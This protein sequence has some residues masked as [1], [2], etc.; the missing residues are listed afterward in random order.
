MTLEAVQKG[1]GSLVAL[2]TDSGYVMGHQNFRTDLGLVIGFHDSFFSFHSFLHPQGRN[3]DYRPGLITD[4]C[5]CVQEAS[6]SM[7]TVS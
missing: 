7:N 2:S 3:L 5:C 6:V 1:H 4:I